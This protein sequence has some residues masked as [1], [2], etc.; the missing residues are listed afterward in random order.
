[1]VHATADAA[2]REATLWAD[3]DNR[4]AAS[5]ALG[6]VE[7]QEQ[8][9]RTAIVAERGHIIA[10]LAATLAARMTEAAARVAKQSDAAVRELLA[11]NAVADRIAG[12]VAD[13]RKVTA[14]AHTAAAR[15]EAASTKRTELNLELED[16]RKETQELAAEQSLL[17][18]TIEGLKKEEAA[19]QS[20]LKARQTES[21]NER[22]TLEASLTQ[23]R[24]DVAAAQDSMRTL[25][26]QVNAAKEEHAAVTRETDRARDEARMQPAPVVENASEARSYAGSSSPPAAAA[27]S[28]SA[29]Y[30]P[31]SNRPSI[32]SGL[33]ALQNVREQLREMREVSAAASPTSPPRSSPSAGSPTLRRAH[34]AYSPSAQS[35]EPFIGTART[36]RS[37]ASMIYEAQAAQ[38][39]SPWKQRLMKLQGDLRTLRSELGTTGPA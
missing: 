12:D 39:P 7:L 38:G 29:S 8:E 32:E 17:R 1:M 21:L 36:E 20:A 9:G 37:S 5:V 14:E 2:A 11:W 31:R 23:L 19:C 27:L 4:V 16:A 15:V 10:W 25:A 3:L 6:A 34:S 28:H 24:Q 33:A 22:L 13:E 18:Q 30:S 35:H 26:V